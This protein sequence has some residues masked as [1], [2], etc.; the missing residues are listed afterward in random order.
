MAAGV[1]FSEL[2]YRPIFDRLGVAAQLTIA[3]VTYPTSEQVAAGLGLVALDKS[4]GI[5]LAQGAGIIV[6]TVT[7]VAEFI[8]GDLTALGITIDMVDGGSVTL[9]GRK[10]NVLSHRMNPSMSGRT[11]GTVFLQLEGLQDDD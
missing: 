8:Y 5:P 2:L 10:W 11:D 6:E 7:P 1:N 3:G 4:E 9:N